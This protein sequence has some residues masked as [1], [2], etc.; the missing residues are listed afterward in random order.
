MAL[1]GKDGVR[2]IARSQ[3]AKPRSLQLED[4]YAGLLRD[5]AAFVADLEVASSVLPLVLEVAK[6]GPWG[7]EHPQAEQP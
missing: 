6:E 7:L 3:L 4:L 5:S 1:P 2:S